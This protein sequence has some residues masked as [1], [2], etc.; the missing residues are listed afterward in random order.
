[1]FRILIISALL[2]VNLGFSQ[3]IKKKELK[4]T[5]VEIAPKIDANLND[6]A[7]ENAGIASDFVMFRPE[8][9]KKEPNNIRS[10]VK[11]VY[12]DEAIYFGAYLYDDKPEEIPMEFQTRDNFGN[13]DFFGVIINSQNDGI[14]QKEFF[15]MSTGNQN[16]AQKTANREDFSWNAVWDS[17]VKVVADGWIVEMKIPYAALRF[18]S[19]EIQTW[20][21]NFHRNHR[22]E[23]HQYSWNFIDRT[24]GSIG[25]YDGL[26][27]GIKNIKPPVRLSVDPYIFGSVADYN[28]ETDVIWNA[29]MDIK[30]GLNENFTLDATLIPDFGQT[31][32]DNITLNLGPFE[33]KF[34]EKRAFFTEGLELFSKGNFFYSRR[35]GNTPIGRN[36]VTTSI[37]ESITENPSTV[38]MLNAIKISGRIKNGLGIGVFNAITKETRA[39]IY[40]SDTDTNR[41]E[42]T[43][44]LANYSVIV[45]DKQF[46]KNSSVS[47][48]NTNVTR[49]GHY[50][51][52]NVTGLLYDIKTKDSKYGIDGKLAMSNV[53]YGNGQSP[54]TGL[55]GSFDIG[56]ISGKHQ[57]F[58]EVEFMNATYN[59]NDLGF[60]RRNNKIEYAAEYSYR[61]FEPKGIFNNYGFWIWGTV[62]YLM[63]L[64]KTTKSYQEKSNLYYGN[65]VNFNFW[66]NTKKQ[67]NFGTNI[68]TSLGKQYSYYE[69]RDI[70]NGRFFT[71]N[72]QVGINSWF[73]T[74]S[75]KKVS[76]S[77][78]AY[79]GFRID[80]TRNYLNAYI[81]PK[82]RINDR[83]SARY[84]FSYSKA[85][86]QKEFVTKYEDT[87]IFG[88]RNSKV[89][90]NSLSASYNF[91]TKAGLDLSFRH[92]WQPVT[93][94]NKFYKLAYNGDLAESN[95]K[96]NH[97]V[98]FNSWNIDLNFKWEFSPGSELVALYRN[99][100]GNQ[101]SQSHLNFNENLENLFE[102]KQLNSVSL[103]IVYY[104]DYN[105]AK[106]WL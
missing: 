63:K 23:Q 42:V 11:V 94:D 56:K 59:K 92:N 21:I 77:F 9:G 93:Y 65:K 85:K 69:P 10:V 60:Q 99:Q 95:Y 104:L 15:V 54:V 48:I 12:D 86:N 70:A 81:S 50:R 31:A 6:S 28:N 78:G 47:F 103:K 37:N 76:F 5:R 35:V 41:E 25:Q 84:S 102:Q 52:A 22:K 24:K 2:L 16:D 30:Y 33:Q 38:D 19:D 61:R 45:I 40:N 89:V 74:N 80:E 105:Q 53:Y 66:A 51:D 101:D 32:F 29:G 18:S 13:A 36:N 1:M 67:Q 68:S 27:T 39:T 82:Y 72:P 79:Y 43:E 46:H 62:R 26:L 3:E 90:N 20:S 87:I 4:I 88:N 83:F 17:S 73:N 100:I 8:S 34:S 97:N 98:N 64:D 71:L 14:N 91:S 106:N 44:P 75:S 49:N 7:W 57:Y 58:F 96:D 55:E